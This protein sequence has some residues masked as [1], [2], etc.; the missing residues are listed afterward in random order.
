MSLDDHEIA[1]LI[2]DLECCRDANDSVDPYTRG[3]YNGIE[4]ALCC[5]EGREPHYRGPA[6]DD[7]REALK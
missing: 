2:R 3:L 7:D 5:I 6:G 1:K 4:F